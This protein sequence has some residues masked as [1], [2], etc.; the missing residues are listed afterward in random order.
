MYKHQ[1]FIKK[2]LDSPGLNDAVGY[3][4]SINVK[5]T[6][7]LVLGELYWKIIGVHHLT[8]SENA[9]KH[10][11]YLDTLNGSGEISRHEIV[12]GWEGQRLD[13]VSRNIVLDKPS[14]EP[15]G[16][17]D[18]Y[19]GQKVWAK[20]FSPYPSETV[21][22]VHTMHPDEPGGNTLGHHSFHVAWQLIQYG[23]EPPAPPDPDPEPGEINMLPPFLEEL[24][25]LIQK[26]E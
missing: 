6:R 3:G 23:Q 4:V 11:L 9:G 22:N 14:I 16:N 15:S 13:E 20:V 18:I 17:I 26:Y 21:L 19:W 25:I 2:W 8:P 7:E 10:N 1:E 5:S 24:K 12:W